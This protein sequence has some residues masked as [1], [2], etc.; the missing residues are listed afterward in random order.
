M[1]TTVHP[2]LLWESAERGALMPAL[3]GQLPPGLLDAVVVPANSAADYKLARATL[4]ALQLGPATRLVRGGSLSL[5]L[6]ARDE[7]LPSPQVR[8]HCA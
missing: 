2:L 7:L 6:K 3:L 5:L 8:R 1:I 4:Q